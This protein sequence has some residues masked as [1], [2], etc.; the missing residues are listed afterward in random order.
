[1]T[2]FSTVVSEH[3]QIINKLEACHQ[4]IQ[5][6]SDMI[7]STFKANKKLLICGNGGSAADSQHIATEFVVRYETIRQGLPAIALTTDS[8][9][10]TAQP[11]DY[12]FASVFSRQIETL[13]HEGDCLIAIS[14]S[15][16]STNIVEAL[17]AARIKKM[18]TIALTGNDG[19]EL[20]K[21][22]DHTVIVPSKTTARIQEAHILIAHWWCQQADEAF[23][24]KATN[25]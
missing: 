15:G 24:L 9:I 13:G 10:L 1:M 22:A 25:T 18:N 6:S 11:N 17:K 8:S 19:G 3:L 12:N 14:T 16:N 5:L 21:L 7:L 23:S 4:D 20:A 2:P